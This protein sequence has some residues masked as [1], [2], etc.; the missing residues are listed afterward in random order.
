[1]SK[2]KAV[3]FT[4]A[5]KAEILE[6]EVGDPGE[7]EIL[8]RSSCS[9]I[10][11]GSEMHMYRGEGNLPGLDLLPTSAGSLP[12]PVK[13]GY[14]QI[15]L[16]EKA[17]PGSVHQVGDQV[18]CLYPHQDLFVL[19]DMFATPVPKDL[20]PSRA[21]FG[22]NFTT[23][24]NA[25]ITTPALMGDCV[26][27]SGLGIIGSI[28]GS[29]VRRTASK[30]VLVDS[31]AGRRERA[32]GWI[33]ADR[34]VAPDEAEGVIADLTGGRGVDLYF[35][36]SGAP[37][38]LQSAI[39]NTALEGTITA[40]SW[41]GSKPVE[42]RLS[43]EFHLRRQKIFSTG[44]SVPPSL[45]PRWDH[46]RMAGVAWDYLAATPLDDLL[47]SH[48]VPFAEAPKAFQLV[49]DPNEGSMAVLLEH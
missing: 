13:F 14:Q 38:A 39:N 6:E 11:A 36:A 35:E 5:R 37:P 15:G 30:L 44:P 20:A 17:G 47:L 28:L 29:L 27:V 40:L 24:L 4:E 22:S 48:R 2:S 21:A 18:W 49:D 10:S 1:M 26:A 34:V 16:V 42:L 9:L 46:L 32:A 7:G 25:L 41:Y 31:D 12:F 19:P 43:P 8:V 45:A 3:W 23:A 33:G